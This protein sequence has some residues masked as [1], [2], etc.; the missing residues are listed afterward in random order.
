VQPYPFS[1]TLKIVSIGILMGEKDSA[2]IWRGPLKIGAIRQFISDIYWGELDY[3]IVD[4]PPGTGDEP[5]TVAQT[6]PDAEALVVTT[7]Q[8]ISLA[9]VR[10]S[11]NFC[12][13]VNMKV[14]G[15]VENMSGYACPHC[16]EQLHL[17]GKGGGSKMAS[18]MGVP[19]LGEIPI[20]PEIVLMSDRGGIEAL[21][22]KPDMETR[23]AYD[24]I[25]DNI[26]NPT[27]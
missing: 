11:I 25:I 24:R 26:I 27:V 16:G 2:V 19:M 6:I 9:D 23:Q 7:P 17:F 8:E 20:D 15:V 21:A 14:L 13:Q 3:L 4:S 10:K 12:R 18:H 22:E 1:D 5:L